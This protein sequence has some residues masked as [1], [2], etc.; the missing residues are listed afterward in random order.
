MKRGQI[1][2]YVIIGVIVLT[3]VVIAFYAKDY[4]ANNIF[5]RDL[6]KT[7]IIP[8]KVK[9][10]NTFIQSC[11]KETS[12]RAI[13]I[14]GQQGGYTDI[15]ND[16]YP[17]TQLNL[18]SN[19][20]TIFGSNKVAYWFYEQPN[21]VQKTQVPTEKDLE[22]QLS[23]YIE[24][25][26]DSCLN[27]FKD[28]QEFDISQ[29][30]LKVNSILNKN[31][32]E[33]NLDFPLNI[34][35]K[36]FEF[37][38][39]KFSQEF[40]S[41]LLDLFN[42]AKEIFNSINSN[43]ILE[44]KTITMLI[45]N[46]DIPYSGST[47][48][49]IPKIWLIQDVEKNLKN[50]ISQNIQA[51]KVKGSNYVLS[52]PENNYFVID[53]QIKD[54]QLNVNFIYSENWPI[55]MEINPR[56]GDI[57]KSQ[58]V[59]EKLG[60]LRGL[61][62][63][64]ACINTYHF[65]YDIKYPVLVVLNKNDYTFQFGMQVVVD[66][67]EPR[68]R[69]VLANSIQDFDSRICDSRKSEL[70]IFTKDIDNKPLDNVEIKYKCINNQ[71]DIGKTKLNAYNDAVSLEKY[72]FCV[73][74]AVIAS[75]DNYHFAKQIISTLENSE[76][77]LFLEQYKE[78]DV[79][80]ILER[81]G[82]GKIDKNEQVYIQFLEDEK[83]HYQ[84]VLFPEIKKVKLISGKYR[85]IVYVISNYPEGLSLREQIIETCI[86]VPKKGILSGVVPQSEKKCIKTVIPATTVDKVVSGYNEFE[87]EVSREDLNK[88]KIIV[89]VPY[90]GIP[91]KLSEL[92]KSFE[93]K[94]VPKPEFK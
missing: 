93:K 71:C 16:P 89:H 26:I 24:T 83:E 44:Y 88:N 23:N 65:I 43:Q 84:T 49:C 2:V 55:N 9:P 75:K 36:D 63:S 47:D 28:F 67:N 80:V 61:A 72:P 30:D 1:T 60:P 76:T 87:F 70:T 48:E 91:T 31:S 94:N 15:P 59:T 35:I 81:A 13:N 53:S 7:I 20:L 6:E 37:K 25:N 40:N 27:N 74:G 82:S 68:K 19:A 18:V 8:D 54:S 50:I 14:L 21:G 69:T 73:N 85:V 5:R 52:S 11:L 39:N 77:T 66:H 29:G 4:V 3:S 51:L 78:L 46:E 10:I 33:I 17:S 42:Q 86:A 79:D 12:E 41:P 22:N 38:I 58:S 34:K 62:E 56:E 90:R 64:F 57:L 92:S 32:V 45:A